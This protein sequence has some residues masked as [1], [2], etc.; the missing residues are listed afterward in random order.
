M[1]TSKAYGSRLSTLCSSL[2]SP[3]TYPYGKITINE[4]AYTTLTLH[5]KEVRFRH[6]KGTSRLHAVERLCSPYARGSYDQTK[7]RP[8]NA[9]L[10]KWRDPKHPPKLVDQAMDSARPCTQ[11]EGNRY[12][13]LKWK[14][15]KDKTKILRNH[16][17]AYVSIAF[18]N[19]ANIKDNSNI[20]PGAWLIPTSAE[21]N[22]AAV[23]GGKLTTRGTSSATL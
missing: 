21:A 20:L 13:M 8:N 14:D 15:E 4:A 12:K 7:D 11:K 19:A 1:P 22:G 3:A 16:H 2:P 17:A 5:P 18:K 23:G 9:N 6:L 10:F